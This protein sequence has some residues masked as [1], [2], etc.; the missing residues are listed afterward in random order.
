MLSM[1]E[2]SISHPIGG[3][4][5]EILKTEL[6]EVCIVY[7]QGLYDRLEKRRHIGEILIRILELAGEE[8]KK[9]AGLDEMIKK[10]E[11][12]L[13]G[14]KLKDVLKGTKISEES[15]RAAGFDNFQK[16]SFPSEEEGND[17]PPKTKLLML[18]QGKCEEPEIE[19]EELIEKTKY[20]RIL[21]RHRRFRCMSDDP[22][23]NWLAYQPLPRVEEL[24]WGRWITSSYFDFRY[25]IDHSEEEKLSLLE[26]KEILAHVISEIILYIPK[27]KAEKKADFEDIYRKLEED[28]TM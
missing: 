10:W 9:L 22:L 2:D 16:I 7:L 14:W 17:Y 27:I 3:D 6:R 15:L 26:I 1:L 24:L 23:V 21:P 19:M 4:R 25:P 13:Y 20:G 18:F 8:H 5:I 12:E 11:K 28:I